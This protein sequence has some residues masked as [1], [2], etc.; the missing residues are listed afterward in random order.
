MAPND[1][2]SCFNKTL[3]GRAASLNINKDYHAI[4]FLSSHCLLSVIFYLTPYPYPVHILASLFYP[5]TCLCVCVWVWACMHSLVMLSTL[6]NRGT[7]VSISGTIK[8]LA[9]IELP[10]CGSCWHVALWKEIACLIIK[11]KMWLTTEWM[12]WDDNKNR[13]MNR[14]CRSTVVPSLN[15]ALDSYTPSLREHLF[16]QCYFRCRISSFCCIHCLLYIMLQYM[17]RSLITVCPYWVNCL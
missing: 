10:S 11:S 15:M 7:A 2:T 8:C 12:G 6:M 13:C 1:V 17:Y 5:C 9:A 14:L 4:H 3:E 16:V